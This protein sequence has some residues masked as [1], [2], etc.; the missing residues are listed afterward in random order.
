LG[1]GKLQLYWVVGSYSYIG[2]WEIADILGSGKLELYWSVVNYS[3]IGQ[4][5]IA[6][7]FALFP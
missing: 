4:C 7:I 1:S 2:Q 5:A 6:G 3:Y